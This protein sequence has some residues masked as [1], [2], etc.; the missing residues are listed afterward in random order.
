MV[1]DFDPK[2]WLESFD[3]AIPVAE[4]AFSPRG[5][6]GRPRRVSA[7]FIAFFDDYDADGS[8]LDV[9]YI[10]H[11]LTIEM[12]TL[13][14]ADKPFRNWLLRQKI[15]FKRRKTWLPSEQ[16]FMSVFY[17]TD[18]IFEKVKRSE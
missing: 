8:D 11:D 17:L 12:Y 7:P 3:A 18:S 13:D 16:M 4:T 6:D 1:I 14:G 5:S 15:H 2:A 9:E 10:E